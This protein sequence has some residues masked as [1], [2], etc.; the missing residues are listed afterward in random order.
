[1]QTIPNPP[2]PVPFIPENAPFSEEQRAWLNGFLAGIFSTTPGETQAPATP[3]TLLWGSQTGTCETLSRKTAKALKKQGFDPKV[4]DLSEYEVSELANEKLVV[5]LTSTYGDGEAPDNAKAFYDYLHSDQAMELS[6]VNYAVLALGD[7][8]YTHFCKA[9]VDMDTRLK[10]L[11]AKPLLER[12]DCDTDYDEPFGQWLKD[13]H[14]ALTPFKSELASLVQPLDDKEDEEPTYTKKNPYRASVTECY[15]LNGEGSSKDVRHVEIDLGD[16]GLSYEAGD[17]IG[18]YPQ[19][20]EELVD[21]LIEKLG[22]NPDEPVT[23]GGVNSSFREALIS[24]FNINKLS[25]PM[26][27]AYQ[28]YAKSDLL[29]ELLEDRNSEQLKYFVETN[30]LIDLLDTVSTNFETADEFLKVLPLLQ[31][32]LYSISSSPKHDPRKVTITVGTVRYEMKGR[33]RKG[34]ASTFLAERL[35]EDRGV[36][37]FLHYNKDFRLPDNDDLPVIMVGPGTGIAPFRAFLQERE[38]RDARGQNWLFFGDQH[39]STDFLYADQ[40]RKWQEKGVLNKLTTAFSRD[41]NEKI[42]VQHRMMEA[43][44]ELYKWLEDGAYFYVCGDASRMAKD[45][46][47]ALVAILRECADLDESAAI[48]YVENLKKQKRYQRDVY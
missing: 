35:P 32:R 7:T 15:T 1:M 3:V 45:V 16:S 25:R 5:L 43:S 24:R 38:A 19:N 46:D 14:K 10:V 31:P 41:Q 21:E 20:C 11:G 9:G 42:Y 17:A 4:V 23:H 12:V 34:V 26:I 29:A 22:L 44:E 36:E 30:H 33:P 6:K 47:D 28:A 40:L 39:S 37:V 18:V 48:E 8:S 13:L 27:A 2:Q